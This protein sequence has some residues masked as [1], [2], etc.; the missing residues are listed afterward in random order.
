MKVALADS[1]RYSVANL[2]SEGEGAS[3]TESVLFRVSPFT[4]DT[5]DAREAESVTN[6]DFKAPIETVL[7]ND[8]EIDLYAVI[9]RVSVTV[10][11]EFADSILPKVNAFKIE[12][13]KAALADIVL[14]LVD[15]FVIDGVK[16][17]FAASVLPNTNDFIRDTVNPTLAEMFWL[18]PPAMNV[19]MREATVVV[20]GSSHV[21]SEPPTSNCRESR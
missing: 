12:T 16:V 1:V 18:I 8:A 20:V 10:K 6:L 21:E 4:N 14:S 13:L 2:D 5:V 15:T 9:I 3:V 11:A 17:A 7:A 19:A